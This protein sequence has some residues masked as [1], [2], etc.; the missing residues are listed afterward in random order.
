MQLYEIDAVETNFAAGDLPRGAW[1]QAQNGGRIHALAAS[2]FADKPECA[3]LVE[4]QRN[5]V[6]GAHH[7]RFGVE[8]DF[9]IV[10]FQQRQCSPFTSGKRDRGGNGL[11]ESLANAV[12]VL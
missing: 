1:V 7:A 4:V 3:P 9:Q 12:I 8:A 10:D 5:A 11:L 2:R 6:D